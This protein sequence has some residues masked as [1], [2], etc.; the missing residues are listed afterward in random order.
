MIDGYQ[1]NSFKPEQPVSRAEFAALLNQVF[2]KQKTPRKLEFKDI[3]PDFWA[4][5]A[6]EKAVR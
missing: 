1:D 6:I 5:S 4:N 3:Q 2:N